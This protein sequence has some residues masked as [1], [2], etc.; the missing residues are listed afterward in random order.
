MSEADDV[1]A[2]QNAI[3][4]K[5]RAKRIA[6]EQALR[7]DVR[8]VIAQGAGYN[9]MGDIPNPEYV[10]YP[11]MLYV[12]G[13]QVIVQSRAEEN[14]LLGKEEEPAKVM[15][16]DMSSVPAAEVV[17]TQKRRGRPPKQQ[18]QSLPPNLD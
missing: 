9:P 1:I 18:A 8:S 7:R 12:D 3:V 16:I 6:K 4:A 11:K 13:K 5:E 17:Q 10:E 15:E 14:V 2:I